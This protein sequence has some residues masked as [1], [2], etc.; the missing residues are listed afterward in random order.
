MKTLLTTYLFVLFMLSSVFSS[1]QSMD[2]IQKTQT[3]MKMENPYKKGRTKWLNE[4]GFN[5]KSYTWDDS[6][7]NLYLNQSV[8]NRSAGN[9]LGYT[10]G[11]VILFGLLANLAG[12]FAYEVSNNDPNRQYHV[13]KAPYYL[14]GVLVASSVVLHVRSLSKLKKAKSIRERKFR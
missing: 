5:T 10:G 8:K 1:A 7:I 3:V 4:N 11:G 2:S 13:F 9:V 14:G 6:E 12:R